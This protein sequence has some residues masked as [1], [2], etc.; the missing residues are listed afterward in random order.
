ML[1]QD[2]YNA[3]NRLLA[4]LPKEEYERLLPYFE[5]VSL[6]LKQMLYVPNEPIEYTYFVNN[7][8]V[9]L[10]TLMENGEAIEVATVGNE[11]MVGLP[12]FLGASTIPGEAFSQIPG[13]AMRMK[14]DVFKREVTP[15]CAMYG[16][17]QRYTQTLFNQIA[18]SAAC[19]RLHSI[20]ER[21]C[22]WM[23]MTQDRVGGSE[24][25][26]THEFLGQMLGVRRASVSVTAAVLQ[27][28]GIIQY[29][30][31]KMRIIDSPQMENI[32]CECY[33]IIKTDFDRLLNNS[34]KF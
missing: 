5:L 2:H 10:L 13:T 14:S 29:N 20:E 11:G 30:R 27:K 25:P 33:K 9:S 24:F 6:E 8:I 28:A 34:E 21:F 15:G 3:K 12:I 7:G 17:L 16:L 32:A 22:R 18:Q 31:G 1:S 26:M 4:A 19:N 23:L